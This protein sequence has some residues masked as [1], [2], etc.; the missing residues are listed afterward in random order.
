MIER[1]LE[2]LKMKNLTPGQ[3][4]DM[5]NVQRSAISHLISGRNKPSLEFIQKLLKTFPEINADWMLFGKG[6]MTFAETTDE[7][8]QGSVGELFPP[9]EPSKEKKD[10]PGKTETARVPKRKWID[11]DGRKPE[12]IVFFYKDNTFREF[13]PE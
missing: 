12:K 7:Q 9:G 8:A 3:F 6:E 13:L 1:I 11:T 4:A 10:L 2:I 5:I